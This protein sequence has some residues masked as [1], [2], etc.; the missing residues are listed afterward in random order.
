M[1][2][3]RL[4][5][6]RSQVVKVAVHSSDAVSRR[7][8]TDLLSGDP[9]L[10]VLDEADHPQA[11]VTVVVERLV[12]DPALSWL[13]RIRDGSTAEITPRCVLVTDS[14]RG[15]G[16]LTA[17]ECGVAAVLSRQD[18][19]RTRLV[20]T[21]VSVSRGIAHLPPAMQGELLL[22]LDRV[23]REVLEPNG[24]T[25]TGVDARER[26]VL[27]LLAE[28]LSTDEI[29]NELAYSERTVKN[30]L[31]G[32]MSRHALNTRAHAVAYALRTGIV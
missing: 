21:V 30:V 25:M 6:G 31:Y 27:R 28:G 7:G 13:R 15:I 1:S 20:E 9:R 23:R 12:G 19:D 10:R 2:Q 32:L 29:A 5:A 22:Q 11:S 3:Q 16:V 24:L 18:A 4:H 8:A 17:V 26:D 14:A